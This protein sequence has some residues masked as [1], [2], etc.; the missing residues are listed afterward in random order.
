[1]IPFVPLN[2]SIIFLLKTFSGCSR[3]WNIYLPLIC[4]TLKQ[5][6][7]ASC[8]VQVPCNG[9]FLLL[10][11]CPYA[12][13]HFTYPKDLITKCIVAVTLNT[14]LLDQLKSKKSKIFYSTFIFFLPQYPS[15]LYIHPSYWP[16]PFVFSMKNLF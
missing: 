4:F 11:S 8:V 2:I 12:V 10:P 13:N 16:P 9:V 3:V 6:Y 7:T 5:Q 14:Y 1:M 15:F